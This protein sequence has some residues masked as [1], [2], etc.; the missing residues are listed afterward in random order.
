MGQEGSKPDDSAHAGGARVSDPRARQEQLAAQVI[1]T[2]DPSGGFS[3]ATTPLWSFSFHGTSLRSNKHW[4]YGG[5][6]M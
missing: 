5:I 3:Q 2:L 4:I 1:S 6:T